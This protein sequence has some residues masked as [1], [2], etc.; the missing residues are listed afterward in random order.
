MKMKYEA[1]I[2][3]SRDLVWATF[4][5]PD[6]RSRW[7]S[8]LESSTHLSGEPGQ[9]GSVSELVL[10]ENGRKVIMTET[11]TERQKPHFM[12][13]TYDSVW[14]TT[15]IVNHFEELDDNT[16]RFICYTNM[17]FKGAMKIMS[18]FIAKSI[19]ARAEADLDRF[20]LLVETEAAGSQQ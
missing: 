13:G 2:Q 17:N 11:V 7:Q 12:A 4:D 10:N 6:N 15:L 5:N 19:R 16:T 3:A 1:S 14:A 9:P 8:A 20:K 18:L